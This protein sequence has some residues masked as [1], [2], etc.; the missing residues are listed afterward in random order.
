VLTQ[1]PPLM[2]AALARDPVDAAV[3]RMVLARQAQEYGSE[4]ARQVLSELEQ[5]EFGLG[6]L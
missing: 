5:E 1:A 2:L 6:D 4:T 3:A